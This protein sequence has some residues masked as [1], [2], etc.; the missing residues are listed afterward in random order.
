[1]NCIDK[2]AVKVTRPFRRLES[3]NK[4]IFITFKSPEN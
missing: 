3:C 1:M 4:G 2:E